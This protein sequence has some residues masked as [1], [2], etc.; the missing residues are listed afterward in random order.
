[1]SK[2]RCK[3]LCRTCKRIKYTVGDG[4]CEEEQGHEGSHIHSDYTHNSDR[5]V[6]HRWKR[7]S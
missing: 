1:M 7:K 5:I 3:S 4:R 2:K 6:V